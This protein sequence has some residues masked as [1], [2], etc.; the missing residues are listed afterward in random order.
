MTRP[1]TRLE[2]NVFR[3]F[4]LSGAAAAFDSYAGCQKQSMEL[5]GTTS[6]EL[7]EEH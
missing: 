6:L 3:H 5:E 2:W 1:T 4:R 7:P